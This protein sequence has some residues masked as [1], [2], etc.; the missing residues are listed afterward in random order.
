VR[1]SDHGDL[2]TVDTHDESIGLSCHE[3]DTGDFRKDVDPPRN[4]AKLNNHSGLRQILS[5]EIGK[6]GA[7]FDQGPPNTL[8]VVIGTLDP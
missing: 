4:I 2:K 5:R 8:R 3:I 6:G 1:S 7:K